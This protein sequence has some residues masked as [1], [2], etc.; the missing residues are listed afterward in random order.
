[1]SLQ[2]VRPIT[3]LHM[4]QLLLITVSNVARRRLRSSHLKRA[5]QVVLIP[6]LLHQLQVFISHYLPLPVFNRLLLVLNLSCTQFIL[7]YK[8]LVGQNTLS[9]F[10]LF[11]QIFGI[12]ELLGG[13]AE[14]A[15]L[16]P[17][18]LHEHLVLHA[19]GSLLAQHMIPFTNFLVFFQ[20]SLFGFL[21]H[22]LL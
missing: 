6:L 1:M 20:L 12:D 14:L 2:R 9:F 5:I 19:F 7:L 21:L 15:L 18:I 3:L 22:G 10:F 16:L 13:L 17:V 4:R 8:C 11:F